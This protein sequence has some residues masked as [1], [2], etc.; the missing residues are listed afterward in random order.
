MSTSTRDKLSNEI[1][2]LTRSITASSWR[3]NTTIPSAFKWTPNDSICNKLLK[4]ALTASLYLTLFCTLSYSVLHSILQSFSLCL[5]VSHCVSLCL[6]ILLCAVCCDLDD[7]FCFWEGDLRVDV[8]EVTQVVV[9]HQYLCSARLHFKRTQIDRIIYICT[10]HTSLHS[11]R[12]TLHQPPMLTHNACVQ[13]VTAA[14]RVQCVTAAA[15]VQSAATDGNR[16]S[17]RKASVGS[18]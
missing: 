11:L 10:E 9:N 14:A 4:Y 2:F 1:A 6:C 8:D 17:I 5:T 3:P 15:R 18:L 13:C 12:R 7:A 16:A